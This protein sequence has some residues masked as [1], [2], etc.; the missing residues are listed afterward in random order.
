MH[1]KSASLGYALRLHAKIRLG[2][3]SL[4]GTNTLAYYENSQI[5]AVNSFI[6]LAPGLYLLSRQKHSSLF[7]RSEQISASLYNTKQAL[8]G[9][10]KMY[11][12]QFFENKKDVITKNCYLFEPF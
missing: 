7:C 9:R 8:E 6:T 5:A 4:S 11:T 1:L 12:E 2:W 3:K 10:P